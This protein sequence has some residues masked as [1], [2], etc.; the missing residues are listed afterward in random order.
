M[1]TDKEKAQEIRKRLKQELG[2][3]SKM[4][5]V[6]MSGG[7]AIDV[8]I[9]DALV[10]KKEV[11]RVAKEYE[12][13][14]RDYNGSHEILQGGNTFIFVK[15]SMEAIAQK[16]SAYKDKVADVLKELEDKEE[17]VGQAV[18]LENGEEMIISNPT[19]RQGMKQAVLIY[20]GDKS[21]FIRQQ[22]VV[23]DQDGVNMLASKMVEVEEEMNDELETQEEGV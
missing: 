22:Y 4:V 19:K 17:G 9:K 10:N 7:S 14:R 3:N 15:V 20:Q 6:K 5:S 11:E 1:K 18:E 16:A 21:E 8:E 12:H 2:Y 13:V 23:E